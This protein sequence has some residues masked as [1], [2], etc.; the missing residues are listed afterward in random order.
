MEE[1]KLNLQ[2]IEWASWTTLVLLESGTCDE[3]L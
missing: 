2:G 1:F 3:I